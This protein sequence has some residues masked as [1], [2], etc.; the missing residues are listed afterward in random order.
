M[1]FPSRHY[2]V[3]LLLTREEKLPKYQEI[4]TINS[5]GGGGGVKPLMLFPLVDAT[6]KSQTR[7]AAIDYLGRKRRSGSSFHSKIADFVLLATLS[8]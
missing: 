2:Q 7:L 4:W 5:V 6:K 8:F 1:E 3:S